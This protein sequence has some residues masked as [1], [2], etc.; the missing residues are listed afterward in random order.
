MDLYTPLIILHIVGTILGVGGATFIEIHLHQA[1][2]DGTFDPFEKSNM[3]YDFLVTRIGTVV[4]FLSGLGILF[5]YYSLP[6]LTEPT[7]GVFWAKM[8]IVAIITLNA[9]LLHVRKIGLYWGSA[10]SFV[11]WWGA[12]LLG[13]FMTHAVA[14]Y[15]GE[16]LY[17]YLFIMVMY[18]LAVAG[19]AAILE[20]L[21][22]RSQKHFT[23]QK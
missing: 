18:F 20:F 14:V 15:D 23:Q 10:L 6:A 19:G 9:Y 17:S 7:N 1:L 4:T 12:M 2:R 11:S 3:K 22:K 8:S 13:V 16:P 21:R 5:L